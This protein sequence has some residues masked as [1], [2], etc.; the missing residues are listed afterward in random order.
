M[1]LLRLWN[2]IRGYVIILV[3]G[4]FLEKF[5]NICTHRQILLWDIKRHKNC[6]MTMKVTINGFKLLRMVARKSKCRVRIVRKKGLPFLFS[7]YRRRKAFFAGAIIFVGLVYLMTSFIW[8]VEITGNKEL[9]TA[10]VESVLSSHGIKTGVLKYGIDSKKIVSD[11]M[12]DVEKLSWISIN[13]RGTK[14]KVQLRE[15]IIPPELVPKDEPCN[16]VAT[17]EGIIKQFVV[18]EGIEAAAP[19]D[20]VKKGDILISGKIPIKNEKDKFRLVHAMGT[21]KAR[22]WYEEEYPVLQEVVEKIATGREYVDYSIKLFTKNIDLFH[23]NNKYQ[24]YEI[25]EN[26]KKLTIGEDLVFPFELTEM[27]YLEVQHR[28]VKISEEDARKNAEENALKLIKE[29]IP[30]NAEMVKTDIKYKDD[31]LEGLKVQVTVE[32]IEEIGIMEGIGGN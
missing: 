30:E 6:I 20:T 23:K 3:E 1:L 14:V 25:V 12:L 21:V 7:R 32:C 10:Y 13:V 18:K 19:G 27:K 5:M 9:E 8:S 24:Y 2:Y 29:Q 11:L 26:N 17:K 22:T 28:T 15:R 31:E 16:I 4:Y